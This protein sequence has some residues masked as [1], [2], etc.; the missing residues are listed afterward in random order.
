[1]IARKCRANASANPVIKGNAMSRINRVEV[2]EFAVD[3][4]DLGW[5]SS[6]FNIVY[7]PNN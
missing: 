3:L 1:L 4:P 2:H 5:D 6:G 7:Q